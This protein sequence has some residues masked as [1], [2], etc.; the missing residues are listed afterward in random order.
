MKGDHC[1]K[2][3]ELGMLLEAT[4]NVKHFMDD[5]ENNH[6]KSIYSELKAIRE[7]M[8]TYRPPWIVV[9]ILSGLMTFVGILVT[10]LIKK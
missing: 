6:L 9:F 8:A 1:T 3:K 4:K 5:M 10:L 2:E 7:K